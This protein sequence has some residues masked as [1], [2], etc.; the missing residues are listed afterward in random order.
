MK[1][2]YDIIIIGAGPAGSAAAIYFGKAGKKVLLLDKATF[3]RDKVCGDAI[4]S[5]SMSILKELN[6][7]NDIDKLA[8]NTIKRLK[9]SSP[10]HSVA[11]I[12]LSDKENAHWGYIIPRID[13]DNS[14]FT[15]AKKYADTIENFNVRDIILEK[16]YVVGVKAFDKRNRETKYYAKLTIGADGF[17]S[18]IARKLK[19]NNDGVLNHTAVATRAYYKNVNCPT[20]R[21]ELHYL[22]E[23]LP[24]YLWIFPIHENLINVGIGFGKA[25]LKKTNRTIIDIHKEAIASDLLK[26][27]FKNAELVGKILGWTL[28]LGSKQR[29]ISGNGFILLGDAAGLVDPLTGEGIGKAMHSAKIAA[30]SLLPLFD[31]ESKMSSLDLKAYDDKLWESLSKVFKTNSR[32]QKLLKSPFFL[33]FITGQVEKREKFRPWIT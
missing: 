20:D 19:I 29:Q 23:T 5:R 6:L 30:S 4:V 8:S 25:S 32:V 24:G 10:N 27:R 15:E 7:Y 14:L 28:P 12:D 17:Q 3:P 21:I 2:D 1:I 13:F 18:I 9:F 26:E 31:T 22:K 33:N 16:G 11:T